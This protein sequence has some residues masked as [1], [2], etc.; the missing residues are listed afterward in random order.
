MTQPQM[1]QPQMTQ[2][3]M[4]QPQMTQMTQIDP[5]PS[6]LS[7]LQSVEQVGSL[8]TRDMW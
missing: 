4:T 1:T 6:G 5:E 7:L 2:P 3:Q 8:P